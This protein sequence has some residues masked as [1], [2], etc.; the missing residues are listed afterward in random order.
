MPVRGVIYG[1]QKGK[2]FAFLRQAVTGR[3][4]PGQGDIPDHGDAAA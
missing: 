1:L 2:T 4:T 3:M